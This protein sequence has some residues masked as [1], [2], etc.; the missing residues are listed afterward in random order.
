MSY[1][2]QEFN[3]GDVLPAAK[4]NEMQDAIVSLESAVEPNEDGTI[5][6]KN[7]KTLDGHGTEYFGKSSEVT[8]VGDTRSEDTNVQD[9]ADKMVFL[10]IKLNSVLNLPTKEYT[11]YSYVFGLMG[12]NDT[13]AGLAHEIAFNNEGIFRRTVN[14]D[15]SK[16]NWVKITDS[17]DLSNFLPLTGG[18][19]ANATFGEALKVKRTNAYDS[20]TTYE[21]SSGV[22]GYIGMGNTKKPIYT[23]E[24]KANT[25]ELLHTGNKPSG[26]Y[27][28]NGDAT[29]RTIAIGGIGYSCVVFGNG[30][31]FIVLP[32][33][34]KGTRYT[35]EARNFTEAEFSFFNGTLKIG[36]SDVA[37][38]ASGVTY[39]YQL[40]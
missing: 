1:T 2:K 5:V 4:V 16:T 34:A 19:V 11:P 35:G 21:N 28:G 26:T 7:A 30:Y 15:N 13:T 40:L 32:D 3:I 39:Y 18:T 17:V 27:T 9:Y 12:W 29:T 31:S 8:V 33:G 37:V 6:A 23:D 10:G 22:L 38:N 25:Y 24:T 36:T 20:V 14:D